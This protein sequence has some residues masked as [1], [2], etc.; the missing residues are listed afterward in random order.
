MKYTYF[1]MC[2]CEAPM[3]CQ[4][5]AAFQTSLFD[6]ALLHGRLQ[7]TFTPEERPEHD[8]VLQGVQDAQHRGD[9]DTDSIGHRI[10]V[11]SSFVGG[12]R[13][14]AQLFQDAMAIVRKLSTPDYFV[15]F[16]CNPNWPEVVAEL[17]PGQ[18]PSDR[19]DLTARVFKMKLAAL[20]QDLVT[21]QVLGTVVGHI[22]VVEFQKRGLPHA[23]ILL[24]LA[25]SDKPRGPE[26]FDAVVCAEI[27]NPDTHPQLYATVTSS[28]M[29][30]PCRM[31]LQ[32]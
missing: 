7:V 25:A 6:N 4:F 27:P 12:P 10:I 5:L 1:D 26:D 19:A 13:H 17:E 30:G 24:I 9:L 8:S 15:T 16:T 21:H 29:H 18:S 2:V 23:H 28:M 11:A 3:Q 31:S 20:L 32:Q 22:H 14:M